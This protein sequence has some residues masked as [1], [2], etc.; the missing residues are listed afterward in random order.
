MTTRARV[1]GI[2]IAAAAVSAG[3]GSHVLMRVETAPMSGPCRAVEPA[4]REV[5]RW[6]RPSK[7][8]DQTRLQSWCDAVG[9]VV[10]HDPG[11]P[12]PA[13]PDRGLSIISW[14]MAVGQGDLLA[15]LEELRKTHP[16]SDVI[17]LL[18]EAYRGQTPPA[19][20]AP[21]SG[22]AGA[23]GQPRP[24]G[25]EDIVA[26]A[27]RTDMYGVY[28]PS[29]RNG[30]DCTVEPREDRGNA[31][32]STLPLSDV[33][34]I[35]LPFSQQRR[36]AV[37]ARV[38]LGDGAVGVISTHFDTVHG[39]RAMGDALAQTIGLLGWK[40]R[41]VVAGDFNSALPFDSGLRELRKSFAELD[42]G[43]GPTH[44]A[45]GRLDHMFIGRQ[46]VSFPC[47]TGD[48]RH[49]SDHSPLIAVFSQESQANP[50]AG[51]PRP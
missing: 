25:S 14:N 7:A 1:A 17:L 34:A 27:K 22:R 5:G 41:V 8:K 49:G 39:H 4:E 26:L 2:T 46:D 29:M 21:G 3:C 36:V 43:R 45:G 13:H 44:Q 33:A 40:A 12:Q 48:E 37:A 19:Q 51:I 28:V 9:P 42:C 35:E 32:L 30:R 38:Q 11:R 50:R 6:V 18:Q 15:L 31:I 10:V 16:D 20:C 24:P 23:I 47:R